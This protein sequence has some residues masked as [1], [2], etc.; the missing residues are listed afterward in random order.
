MM[1]GRLLLLM[2]M[3]MMTSIL[4]ELAGMELEILSLPRRAMTDLGLRHYLAAIRHPKS[5]ILSSWEVTDAGLKE[6]DQ[7]AEL[8]ELFLIG[9]QVTDAGLK[10]LA[11][12]KQLRSLALGRTQVTDA[13]LEPIKGMTQ[14]RDLYL[15]DLKV[16]PAA[17]S[18]LKRALPNVTVAG[19]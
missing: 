4:S 15:T 8:R 13:G 6:L 10:D 5:L 17:V 1:L 2:S 14:L 9:T 19:P 18:A 3:L 7:L 12:M 16:S 11:N